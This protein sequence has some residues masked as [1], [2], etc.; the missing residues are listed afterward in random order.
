M[1]E[2][3]M[4]ENVFYM[5]PSGGLA[6]RMRAVA[7]A[8]WLQQQTGSRTQVI[9]FCDWALNAPFHQLFLPSSTI[10]FMTGREGEI[11]GCPP[12]PS[13]CSSVGE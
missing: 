3:K 1:T 7:S 11:C 13:D 6:N 4:S 12:C 2:R 10:C 5:V 8:Y 9:W